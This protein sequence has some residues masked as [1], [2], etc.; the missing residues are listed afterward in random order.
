VIIRLNERRFLTLGLF[1][2]RM[3][4]HALS[5]RLIVTLYGLLA[6][7]YSVLMPPWEAP[8]ESAHY[9]VVFILAREGRLPAVEE[10][11]EA[12][13]PPLYYWLTAQP[14]RL[15]NHINPA[16]IR[17]YRPSLTTGHPFTRYNWTADNFRFLWGLHILR[18]LNIVWGG[19]ALYF[20]YRGAQQLASTAE[21]GKWPARLL[22]TA[23]V[24]AVGLMPQFAYNSAAFSN[25]PPANAIGALLFWLLI[26][27]CQ[28]PLRLRQLALIGAVA[29]AAP[30]LVKLTI[31]PMSLAVCLMMAY[32]VQHRYRAQRLWFAAGG[33]LL[34]GTL[35][36]AWAWISPASA[37]VL[38]RNL[39]WRLTTIRPDAF[40]GWSF[41]R[42][43]TFYTTSYWGQ[44]GWKTA[45]LPGGL[46]AGMTGLA[47]LGWLASL[48]LLWPEQPPGR[49]W[50]WLLP[51][52]SLAGVSWLLLYRHDP[53]WHMPWTVPAGF[54]ALALLAWRRF[55]RVDLAARLALPITAWR[56]VWL[57]AVLA[58]L[59]VFKNFL[60]TPQYQGR[61]FFPSLGALT[62]LMTAGWYTLL[63]RRLA[64]YLPHLVIL[65]MLAL[66]AIL[67]TTRVLPVFY[68]PLLDR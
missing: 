2:R 17:P 58:L 42:I 40:S 19:L 9:L 6:F 24:A 41:W 66:N 38:W 1:L 65:L 22:P 53:W 67:W 20:I 28:A 11:Y 12:A 36:A 32:Q 4:I 10:T 46:V 49:L 37:D 31:L 8:D 16:I 15:L 62:L 29:L 60:T 33:A 26:V 52:S 47:L 14:F 23:T 64:P 56:A 7:S 45:G 43:T 57:S 68:Q 63:P 13:Q 35:I 44:V 5:F 54:L 21:P 51:A 3:R 61:F 34:G 25:D 18:W 30:L 59:I 48:R 39:F 50:R 55:G 27:L